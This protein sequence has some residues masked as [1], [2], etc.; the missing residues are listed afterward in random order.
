MAT[1]IRNS[2]FTKISKSVKP[3]TRKRVIL[4]KELVSEDVVFHIYTNASGQILLDPQVT[5]AA[6]ELW[7]FE[8]KNILASLDKAMD[9]SRNGKVTKRGSFAKFIDD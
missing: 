4:P 8:N 3:D 5:I 7:V 9:E 2:S 1:I 6:S